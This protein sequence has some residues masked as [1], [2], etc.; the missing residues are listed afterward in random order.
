MQ[1]KN[2]NVI[3]YKI[4]DYYT[5]QGAATLI[6][7]QRGNMSIAAFNAEAK[8][9]IE[10]H[11]VSPADVETLLYQLQ[12]FL[13][14]YYKLTP[15]LDD[16]EISDI[17]CH[18]AKNIRVKRLGKRYA[19]NIT[20]TNNDEYKQF[21]QSIAIKNQCDTSMVNA[22][23]VFT[24]IDSHP[25][26]RLRFDMSTELLNSSKLPTLHIR[27][28]PKNKLGFEDLMQTK[29]YPMLDPDVAS[30]LTNQI[31]GGQSMIV[32]G[33]NASGKT[34]LMNAGIEK[35]PFNLSGQV[36]QESNE[37][38]AVKHPDLFF[39]VVV[40][41]NGEGKIAYTIKDEIK[42]ALMSDNNMIIIGEVKGD[43]ALD[44]INAAYT[45]STCWLSVHGESSQDCAEKIADYAACAANFGLPQILKR[46]KNMNMVVFVEN[47]Q[48]TE[49]S[50]ITGVDIEHECL[51]YELIYSKKQGIK[52]FDKYYVPSLVTPNECLIFNVDKAGGQND[53]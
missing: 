46:L 49:I 24:D 53:E 25:K 31:E 10:S 2:L 28:I 12:T 18:N 19:T 34:T 44:V 39:K 33:A 30:F 29:P 9:L 20:F 38:F 22:Q 16:D 11:K 17:R 21:L 36:I 26:F 4:I 6:Q 42:H 14:G 45:G 23:Q 27:K 35:I 7:V 50:K 1:D 48:V 15:L 40:A 37:L 51:T 5:K 43:E 8:K 3:F 13:F 32:G 41:P 52:N 47:F